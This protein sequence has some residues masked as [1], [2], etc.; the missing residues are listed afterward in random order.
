MKKLKGINFLVVKILLGFFI[1][2]YLLPSRAELGEIN[3]IMKANLVSNACTVSPATINQTVNLGTWATKQFKETYKGVPPKKFIINLL[4]CGPAATGVKVTF[5]GVVDPNNNMLL[6]LDAA[7]TATNLGISILDRN[8][9][10]IK[11]GVE[12]IIY[13]VRANSTNIPL[14]F[15]AQYVAT[16]KNV[17]A[18]TANSQATFVLEYL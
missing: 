8:K 15:Y 6:K 7:S 16:N 1:F 5:S 12:T 4:D 10:M 13:P 18:G 11:P 14:E 17:T 9:N 2:L 3:L